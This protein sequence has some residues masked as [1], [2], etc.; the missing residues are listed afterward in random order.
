MSKDIQEH[1]NDYL[2]YW[3]NSAQIVNLAPGSSGPFTYVPPAIDP[4]AVEKAVDAA[5]EK[6]T[7]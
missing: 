1:Y 7:H 2:R 6:A 5:W 4:T 3:L